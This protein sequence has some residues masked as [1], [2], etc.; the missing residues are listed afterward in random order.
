MADRFL[1]LRNQIDPQRMFA[2]GF[3]DR[4]LGP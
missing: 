2:N 4:M 1:D 3:L